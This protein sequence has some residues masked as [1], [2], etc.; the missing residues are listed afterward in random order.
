LNQLVAEFIVNPYLSLSATDKLILVELAEYVS[1]MR[2][3]DIARAT[4]SKLRW[5]ARQVSK[6]SQ[7]GLLRRVAP[8]TYALTDRPEPQP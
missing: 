4:G 7:L 6:L 2:L 1:G 8:G 5:V 3:E